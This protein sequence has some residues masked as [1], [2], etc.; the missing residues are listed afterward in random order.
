MPVDDRMQGP[1]SADPGQPSTAAAAH[2]A[3][4]SGTTPTTCEYLYREYAILVREPDADRVVER[5]RGDPRRRGLRRRPGGRRA[6]IQARGS[7]PA[8]LVRLTVPGVPMRGCRTWSLCLDEDGRAGGGQARAQGLR[9]PVD[10][11]GD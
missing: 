3:P 7:Q 9:V 10:L 4:I 6:E 1:G 11:P 5:A 2:P 8:G